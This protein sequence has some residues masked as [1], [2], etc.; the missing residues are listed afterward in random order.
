MMHQDTLHHME[1][2]EILLRIVASPDRAW[3]ALLAGLLLIARE[4][5]AP[6][7]ILPG[8]LGGVLSCVALWHLPAAVPGLLI[9]GI[10]LILQARHRF[11]FIPG[12]LAASALLIA[13]RRSG[14]GWTAAFGSVIV[15]GIL[16][17]LIR[18]GM[19]ARR[20]KVRLP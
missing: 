9:C 3:L 13:A 15:I 16:T 17:V 7:L 12:A 18:I 19:L 11:W 5:T 4:C 20:N 6:G 10:L 8:L 1:L 14:T 2:R